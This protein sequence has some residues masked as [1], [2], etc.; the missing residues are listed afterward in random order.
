MRLQKKLSRED[1]CSAVKSPHRMS[2]L[3]SLS[4]PLYRVRPL[5]PFD[6]EIG[7]PDILSLEQLEVTRLLTLRFAAARPCR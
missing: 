3:V 7:M 5:V 2:L 6:C 1:A 4:L